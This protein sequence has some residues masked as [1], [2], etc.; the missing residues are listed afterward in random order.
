MP[1][2]K[3]IEQ[4]ESAQWQH[5]W[6]QPLQP[7]LDELIARVQSGQPLHEALNA[8]AEQKQDMPVRFVPQDALPDGQA[9]ESYIFEHKQVPVRENAHD[10]FHGLMWLRWLQTKARMNALHAAHI[11]EHG[12]QGKRGP[13]RD[14]LTILDE[15]GLVIV[16]PADMLD[17]VRQRRW[18]QALHTRR[19]EWLDGRVQVYVLGHAVYEKLLNPYKSIT[20][21]VWGFEHAV[22]AQMAEVVDGTVSTHIHSDALVPKPF[23]PLPVL[24]I[25]QWWDANE[26]AAFYQDTQVF[27]PLVRS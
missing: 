9:Y 5:A 16:A 4:L 14:A 6:W 8:L 15:S 13:L 25:P 10:F 19:Q 27:R 20:G 26:D 18:Q 12:M 2:S 22:K 24:G 21:H 1:S 3:L 11:A 23:F 7:H 17:D